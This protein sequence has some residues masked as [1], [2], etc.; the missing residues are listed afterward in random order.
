MHGK[1]WS[2]KDGA[3]MIETIKNILPELTI[4]G[5][6]TLIQISPLKI[7][8]WSWLAKMIRLVNG[9]EALEK[10]I[11]VLSKD[12]AETRA[13]VIRKEIIDF[14]EELKRGKQYHLAEFEEVSRLITEYRALIKKHDIQNGYGVAQMDYIEE[15]MKE[16]SAY[17]EDE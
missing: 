4:I 13:K 1:R 11:D 15:Y 2:D 8:P 9:T 7:N 10:R 6:V 14:A 3:N 16:R 12:I 17:H 5:A